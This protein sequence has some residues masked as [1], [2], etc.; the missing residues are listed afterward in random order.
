MVRRCLKYF[1]LQYASQMVAESGIEP[2]IASFEADVMSVL[3]VPW[4]V[5][6]N[7]K[8]VSNL[9]INIAGNLEMSSSRHYF[10][11]SIA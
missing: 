9:R 6:A 11:P 4:L 2:H 5:P 3:S 1:G 7:S 8:S 10:Y